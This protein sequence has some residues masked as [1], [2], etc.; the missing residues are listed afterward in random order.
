MP[1]LELLFP[2]VN[3][4]ILLLSGVP[5]HL[6]H[7]GIR[8]GNQERLV[9]GLIATIILGAVF[10]GG[11]AYE[12]LNAGFTP[13]SGVF[14]S[15]FFTLTGFHGAH[16]TVGLTLL[17]V[18]LVPGLA[19]TLLG[20]QSLCGR[21]RGALLALRGHRL[22]GVVRASVRYVGLAGEYGRL[23]GISSQPRIVG[24]LVFVALGAAFLAA[25]ER[26]RHRPCSSLP[27]LAP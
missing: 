16:V 26:Q 19:R 1:E 21:G 3:T 13:Q 22:G 23:L 17:T 5:M 18:I 9:L 4:I 20:R 24:L 12:Y 25:R 6:A 11:Q 7:L 15:T 2:T 10:L 27:S 8:Q 14:G